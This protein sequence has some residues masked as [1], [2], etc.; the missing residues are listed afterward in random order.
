MPP[1]LDAERVE[2]AKQQTERHRHCVARLTKTL[3]DG[4][5]DRLGGRSASYSYHPLHG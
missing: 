3:P 5:V 2:K 1:P 4:S